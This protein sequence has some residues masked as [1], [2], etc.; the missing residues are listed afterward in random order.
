MITKKQNNRK[1]KH[2]SSRS[3]HINHYCVYHQTAAAAAAA[4]AMNESRL[5]LSRFKLPRV[6]YSF[7][8]PSEWRRSTP[9][10]RPPVTH[11]PEGGVKV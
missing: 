8:S 3:G 6:A 10:A 7:E 9:Y 1:K 4:A 5:L 2:K 11:G